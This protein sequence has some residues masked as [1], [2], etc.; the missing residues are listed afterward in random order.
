LQ[1]LEI[2]QAVIEGH[3]VSEVK[4]KGSQDKPLLEMV[5][6]LV[7]EVGLTYNCNQLTVSIFLGQ[8]TKTKLNATYILRQS[9]A[10][11]FNITE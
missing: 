1:E 2:L 8:Q 5:K 11:D 4:W 9:G 7:E 6:E 10:L 3:S